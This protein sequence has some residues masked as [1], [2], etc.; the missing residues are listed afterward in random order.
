MVSCEKARHLCNKTQY[1]ESSLWERIKLTIHLYTCKECSTYSNKNTKLSSL[2]EQAN[3]FNLSEEDKAA[4]QKE[5]D[6][7]SK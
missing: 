1:N 6:N 7:Q 3:I 4:M 2:C 5:L